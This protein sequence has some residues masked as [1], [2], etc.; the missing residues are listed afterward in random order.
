VFHFWPYGVSFLTMWCFIPDH[1]VF[2]FLTM[3]CFHSW[4]C[5][6]FIPDH[7]VFS[8]LTMWCFY[9]WP[10]VVSFLTM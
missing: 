2:S 10:C 7:V 1:V 8:F 4:P 6:V 5:G 3:W 9:S